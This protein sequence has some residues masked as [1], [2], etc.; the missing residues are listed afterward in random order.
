MGV[1]YEAH[2]SRLDRTVALKFLSDAQAMDPGAIARFRIEARAASALNHPNI[3]T[4]Y[5]IEE[6]EGRNYIAMELLDGETL[7]NRIRGK[8]FE[9]E[10]L[11]EASI[12]IADALDTAHQK[13]IIHRDLKPS[14]IAIT[15]RGHVKILD[16]GLAKIAQ[17]LPAADRPT[18]SLDAAN[19]TASGHVVGTPAYMSPEQARGET[20][21]CRADL[22][23]FGAVLYEMSTGKQAFQ[24]QTVPMIH[25]AILNGEITPAAM[26]NPAVPLELDRIIRTALEK[27]RNL[28]YQSAGEM[29]ADLKRLRRDTASQQIAAAPRSRARGRRVLVA[30]GLAAAFVIA[31]G[32]W[33]MGWHLRTPDVSNLTQ[34]QITTNQAEVSVLLMALSHDGKRLAYSDLTGLHVRMIDGGDTQTVQVPPWFCFR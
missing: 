32:G 25:D 3:C 16:F 30:G 31:A 1:V 19:L 23:S 2:D 18:L 33:R 20:I 24:G 27:D 13:G 29:L 22:F 15:Q 26:F 6:C 10:K 12:E 8:P 34:R 28:R 4:V 11:I 21:D 9:I 7:D 14:N 17:N 5:E